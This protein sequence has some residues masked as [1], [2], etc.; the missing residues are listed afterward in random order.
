MDSMDLI[1]R[2]M[3]RLLIVSESDPA[4]PSENS[5]SNPKTVYSQWRM[6]L[7]IHDLAA[8]PQLSMAAQATVSG[9]D[10]AQALEPSNTEN[11]LVDSF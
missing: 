8:P 5:P 10:L 1:V 4:Y 11:G 3:D 9:T 6:P 7:S 2:F